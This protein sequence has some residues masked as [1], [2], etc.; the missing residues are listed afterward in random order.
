[1][2]MREGQKCRRNKKLASGPC[3]DNKLED[4]MHITCDTFGV[5]DSILALL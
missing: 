1:M 5:R 4:E 3:R 2:R